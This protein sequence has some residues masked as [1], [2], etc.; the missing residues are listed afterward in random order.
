MDEPD[1]T[2]MPVLPVYLPPDTIPASH[3]ATW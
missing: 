1:I 3:N 2:V